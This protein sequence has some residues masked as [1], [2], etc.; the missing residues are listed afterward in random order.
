ML[1]KTGQARG[2]L[3]GQMIGKEGGLKKKNIWLKLYGLKEAL[4]RRKKN[5]KWGD[6][7]RKR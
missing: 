6:K 1:K 3:E 7:E 2:D 4:K 5:N